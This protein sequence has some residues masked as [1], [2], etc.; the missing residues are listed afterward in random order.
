M[1]GKSGLH[2]RIQQEKSYQNN[3][4]FFLRSEKVLKMQGSVIDGSFGQ[5]NIFGCKTDKEPQFQAS[6]PCF[7][8]NFIESLRM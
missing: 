2:I 4:L 7:I 8:L 3:E 5:T 1:L 6:P